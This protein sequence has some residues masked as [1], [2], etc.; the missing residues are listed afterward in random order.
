MSTL[1]STRPREGRFHG[2]AMGTADIVFFV[3]A[4]VAPMGV[5]VALLTLSI[6]RGNGAGV[7]GS[8]LIAGVVL[9]L[10]SAGYVRMSRW[11]TNVGGFY[12]FARRGLGR[13]AGGATAYVALL[14]YNAA[15]IGIFGALA[16]FGSQV[17]TAVVGT[18][19]SWQVCALVAFVVVAVLAYFEVTMS[20]EGARRGAGRRGADPARLR[21]RGPGPERLSRLLSRRR[22]NT[23]GVQLRPGVGQAAIAGLTRCRHP[24]WGRPPARQLLSTEKVM[25]LTNSYR[26]R[27]NVKVLSAALGVGVLI[28]MGAVT[29]AYP[30]SAIGTSSDSWKADTAVTLIPA[31]RT[32]PSSRPQYIVDPCYWATWHQQLHN[33]C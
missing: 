28:T 24:G 21:R 30:T 8:Y 2:G 1:D 17:L 11:I 16:Y 31:T 6:A 20:A 10:F 4:G 14:A 5:G 27:G 9:A 13:R 12:T 25:E 15:T 3:L 22:S 23:A 18:A 26:L 33:N 32:Q 7:P 29:V 19:V